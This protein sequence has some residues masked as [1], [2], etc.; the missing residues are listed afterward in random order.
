MKKTVTYSVVGRVNPADR[1]S[2]EVKYYAQSQAR[3]EMGIREIS[4]RIQQMC[5]VTRA[6]VMA[7]LT[8][9]EEIVS[10]GLQ[11]GEI[12]RLGGLGSLQLSL[13][14]EGA[15]TEETFSDS[16]IE[17]VRVLFRPGTVMQEAINNLAFEKVPVKYAKKD[18]EEDG[19]GA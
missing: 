16:L 15:D 19:M 1:E 7:V 2:G 10:E 11:G 4:E 13:S 14:G 12:V 18:E 3:G 9:M 17:K 8:A 5:T 6:D